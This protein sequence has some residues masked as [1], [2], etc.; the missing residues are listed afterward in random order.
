MIRYWLGAAF[1]FFASVVL[2]C[3]QSDVVERAVKAAPGQ[4]VRVG[5]Y[6]SIRPD[7]TSGPLPAIRL[8]TAPAHGVV[9]VKRAMLKATNVKQCLAI[10]VPAFVAFYR[11][12]QD[13]SGAD[14]FDLEI[15]FTGGRKE[16]Q[17]FKV[18]AGS[19]ANGGQGI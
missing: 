3:A 1:V 15:T 9:S 6:T 8:A 7:C 13:F 12:A 16:I 4:N 19:G 14:Q 18:S 2:A 17:H 10:D 5:I 11:A